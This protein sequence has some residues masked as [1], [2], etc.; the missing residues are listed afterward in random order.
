MVVFM[1]SNRLTQKAWYDAELLSVGCGDSRCG[2]CTPRLLTKLS[3]ARMRDCA[4]RY[5]ALGRCCCCCC[6]GCCGC[7]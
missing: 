4:T 2:H 5:S 7:G 1:R 3:N 6:C